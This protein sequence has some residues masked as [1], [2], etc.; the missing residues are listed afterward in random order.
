[1]ASNVARKIL[2]VFI[3]S[4]GDLV[5]ERRVAKK[6]VDDLNETVS[7]RLGWQIELLGWEETL[8]GYGRPQE[9]INEDVEV[10]DLFIGLLWRRWGQS[11]R[12][13]SSGFEEEFELARKRRKETKTPEI[14][15]FFKKVEEDQ[16]KDPGRQLKRV[17]DFQ[18]SQVAAKE[19]LF[20]NFDDV[21]DWRTQ[22]NKYLLRYILK[23]AMP[24]GL[25]LEKELS[26]SSPMPQE[27]EA[28][29]PS[30]LESESN[31]YPALVQCKNLM[32]SI[33]RAMASADFNFPIEGEREKDEFY[34]ARLQLL[35]KTWLSSR[36]TNEQLTVHELNLLYRHRDQLQA[37]GIE[38]TLILETVL[39]NLFDTTPGWFWF[40]GLTS[41]AIEQFLFYAAFNGRDVDVRKQAVE[42]IK[43]IDTS[44]P[45]EFAQ[46]KEAVATILN[47][48]SEE[49]R[50]A[51]LKYIEAIA[52]TEDIPYIDS[53]LPGQDASVRNE[54]ERVKL[55]IASR[56]N[57]QKVLQEFATNQLSTFLAIGTNSLLR[58]I[59]NNLSSIAKEVLFSIVQ[60]QSLGIT[61]RTF[62]LKEL[63]RRNLLPKET[64]QALFADSSIHIKAACF[65]ELIKL[66]ERLDPQAIRDAL[67][68]PDSGQYATSEHP[69][70]DSLILKLFQSF[71]FQELEQ[72][73]DW[74]TENG[75]IA[76]EAMTLAYGDVAVER[77]RSDLR[78]R[79]EGIKKAS[80]AR[81]YE[82][83]PGI[84]EGF[85]N[86]YESLNDFMR[87]QFAKPALAAL[88]V[89]GDSQ[90][91][92][93]ARSYL[94][95]NCE[96]YFDD[97]K[98][99]AVRI[100]YRFGSDTDL[101]LLLEIANNKYGDLKKEAAKAA[102]KL[103]PGISGVAT[104]FLNSS[105]VSLVV[106]AIDSLKK[107]MEP[108]GD[109]ALQS[110]LN[111]KVD[112]VRINTLTY[113]IDTLSQE[114]LITLLN[115]YLEQPTYF[116]NVVCWIDRILYAP[117]P[118]KEIYQRRLHQ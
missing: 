114:Q 15:L 57:P 32:S 11:T 33:N 65:E 16:L 46:R 113:F 83:S 1:M 6:V 79:F 106:M 27:G 47:D 99:E 89:H 14:W 70:A 34:A 23:L 81:I 48:Q 13:F 95:E 67:P 107:S 92:E 31:E 7:R 86:S 36:Y 96:H 64:L 69:D 2:H 91:A 109:K 118:I 49:V 84:A 105:D 90:D 22:L 87:Y 8:P 40:K 25:P 94:E 60:N 55:V 30:S 52:K 44:R 50:Q 103:A 82:K 63:S 101:S 3:A 75:R 38:A 108:G 24:T 112:S 80:I 26:V 51:G 43:A 42:M 62:A 102:L 72:L 21:D 88:A 37:T 100:L 35:A 18:K 61:I 39:G 68:R 115:A 66:G 116:Y 98:I 41:D 58:E 111:H 5:E 110:L 29:V 71:P 17:L 117:S 73:V 20:K 59:S 56:E 76:Y 77:I 53:L 85:V 12:E 74:Y 28:S 54:A 9:L 10:C 19:L 93:I 104:T 78:E 97:L 4:P 45:I